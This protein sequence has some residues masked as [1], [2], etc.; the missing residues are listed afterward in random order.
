MGRL[1]DE[2]LER[3]ESF[4]DRVCDVADAVDRLCKS[5]RVVDQMYG[6]GTAVAANAFEADEALS[7]ADFC[8]CLGIAGKELSE[9]RYWLRLAGR[10]GWVS[11]RRLIAIQAEGAEL[12]KILGAIIANTRRSGAAR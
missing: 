11:G 5:R 4:A 8:K 1:K 12:K 2:F 9:T 7:R 10:R 3:V 6:A